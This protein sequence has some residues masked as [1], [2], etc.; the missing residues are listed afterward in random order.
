MRK[1]IIILFIVLCSSCSG[2]EEKGNIYGVVT[3]FETA[4][5]MRAAGV[6]LY[7][8]QTLL[9][10]TVTYDDGHF[11]FNDLTPGSYRLTVEMNG[12]VSVE[13][14]VL[15]EEARTARADIQMKLEST[16]LEVTTDTP[17]RVGKT[18]G[19]ENEVEYWL[20]GYVLSPTWDESSDYYPFEK[21]L[22]IS[23]N[24]NPTIENP[25]IVILKCSQKYDNFSA[26]HFFFIREEVY[27]IRAYAR[28]KKGYAYG[29]DRELTVME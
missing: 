17:A 6:S 10:R 27:Y 21:G 18:W 23:D 16:G 4:E 1:Y 13:E 9:L 26:N 29:E 28:N 11:E 7:H 5:P 22:L 24:P 2:I 3:A 12:Y 20:K 8:D 14:T 19:R 25:N 15:V